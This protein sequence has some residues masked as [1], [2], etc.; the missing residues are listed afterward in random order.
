[1]TSRPARMSDYSADVLSRIDYDA[2]RQRR[3][4]N[5]AAYHEALAAE[6]T[7]VCELG[8]EDAPFCYPFVP[9]TEFE[10]K[11]LHERRIFV[12]M[13][14]PEVNGAPGDVFEFERDFA[15]RLLPLPVDQ[16]YGAEE[17]ETVIKAVKAQLG[18]GRTKA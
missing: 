10:R 15:R 6:N 12:P 3:R 2:V 18:E 11:R 14:W 9:R 1:M 16:R 13:F 7:F 4:R 5:F 8:P 17:L